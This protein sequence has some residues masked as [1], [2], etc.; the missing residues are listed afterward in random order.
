MEEE[1]TYPNMQILT[2]IIKD[3]EKPNTDD[4]IK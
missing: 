1:T 2:D 4:T 3:H